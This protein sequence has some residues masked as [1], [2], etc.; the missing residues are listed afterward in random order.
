[1]RLDGLRRGQAL[2]VPGLQQRRH[3]VQRMRPA[4]R[5]HLTGCQQGRLMPAHGRQAA[6]QPPHALVHHGA[7]DAQ[8]L[9]QLADARGFLLLG[10]QRA[11]DRLAGGG[12]P[13]AAA[14][15]AFQYL[16]QIAEGGRALG[17]LAAG[18]L[19]GP[20]LKTPLL[21]P[22][23]IQVHLVHGGAA[24]HA[25]AAEHPARALHGRLG[26]LEHRLGLLDG[27]DMLLRQLRRQLL[28]GLEAEID[29]PRGDHVLNEH[30]HHLSG[31]LE[32]LHPFVGQHGFAAVELAPV[33]EG[34]VYR[35]GEGLVGLVAGGFPPLE[36]GLLHA[37]KPVDRRRVLHPLHQAAALPVAHGAFHLVAGQRQRPG[38]I[39]QQ[40]A[41]LLHAAVRAH[42]PIEID[43]D[44]AV[45]RGGHVFAKK[46]VGHRRGVPEQAAALGFKGWH[47]DIP[48][49]FA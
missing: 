49:P 22:F 38:N 20:G 8:R 16:I 25:Q 28:G 31:Q 17:G 9:K 29:A 24:A 40:I 2:G 23:Q 21:R 10:L 7:A 48:A 43:L 41:L 15:D 3:I 32:L 34:G 14:A 13:A 26:P 47:A 12:L 39:V 4:A 5:S 46:G 42:Q 1:M 36:H 6:V 37:E 44:M 30:E 33:T 35:L 19:D 45:G 27:G 18:G 11:L